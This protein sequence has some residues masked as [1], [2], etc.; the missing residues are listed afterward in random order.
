MK[1][2][3]RRVDN[4]L[5]LAN[6]TAIEK[7]DEC[8]PAVMHRKEGLSVISQRNLG[9]DPSVLLTWSVDKWHWAKRCRLMGFRSASGFA[10]DQ[11]P[12]DLSAHGQMILEEVSDGSLEERLPEGT[13]F[14]T[15]V[16]CQPIILGIWETTTSVVR[17]S[18]TIPSA[19]TAIGRIEDRLRLE[20]LKEDHEL[21]GIKR[22]IAK[23]EAI[24]ALHRSNQKLAALTEPKRED[25]LEEDVRREVESIVRKKLKKAMTRVELLA[26]LRDVEKR[27]KRNPTWKKL[28][29]DQRDRLLADI[30]ADLDTDEEFL[31]P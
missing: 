8:L 4:A 20:Q 7:A 5:A 16:L 6:N 25:S 29:A 24:L 26:A 1:S 10:P 15:F 31:Q 19:K 27:L 13:Y 22:Q 14:Y 12:K 23:N 3:V 21:H 17:F 18:E 28:D 30:V 11:D 9:P 2:T